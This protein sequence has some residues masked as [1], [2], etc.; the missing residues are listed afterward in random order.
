MTKSASS[1]SLGQRREPT[2]KGSGEAILSEILPTVIIQ[3]SRGWVSLKLRELREYRELL[4]FLTWRD[5]MVH[6][7]HTVL[8]AA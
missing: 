1:V 4:Y 2:I 8:G 7:K 6:Y 3:S 5:I